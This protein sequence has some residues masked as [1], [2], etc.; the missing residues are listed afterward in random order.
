MRWHMLFD[1]RPKKAPFVKVE[2]AVFISFST[3]FQV[4][5]YDGLDIP[6]IKE[7]NGNNWLASFLVPSISHLR[8]V[9]VFINNPLLIKNQEVIIARTI[10]GILSERRFLVQGLQPFE[11]WFV[12]SS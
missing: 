5:Y 3:T 8:P 4:H 7:Y 6:R 2:Y 10:G 11:G 1:N 12:L 9:K